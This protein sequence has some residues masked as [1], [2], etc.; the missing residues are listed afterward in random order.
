M[1]SKYFDPYVSIQTVEFTNAVSIN[2]IF[3][4]FI[5]FAWN[6]VRVDKPQLTAKLGNGIVDID[7]K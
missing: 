1:Q 4:R 6:R 2:G 5:I 7:R 3:S